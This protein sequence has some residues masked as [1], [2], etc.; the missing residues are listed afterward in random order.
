M[1]LLSRRNS[2]F[3]V[4]YDVDTTHWT[5]IFQLLFECA[6]NTGTCISYTNTKMEPEAPSSSPHA[7]VESNQDYY[8]A[9]FH[10]SKR[11]YS[12]SRGSTYVEPVNSN[13]YMET[14]QGQ[15]HH[16]G[17]P[18]ENLMA[19]SL[20]E[21]SESSKRCRY[22]LESRL[23]P[24]TMEFSPEKKASQNNLSSRAC[25]S[26][27]PPTLDRKPSPKK[28]IC[29]ICEQP[30]D[31]AG[32][33]DTESHHEQVRGNSLNTM[34]KYYPFLRNRTSEYSSSTMMSVSTTDEDPQV[35]AS[36]LLNRDISC[37]FCERDDFCP[38]CPV[39]ACIQ[40]HFAFCFFCRTRNANGEWLCV[41]CCCESHANRSNA[42]EMQLD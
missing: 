38:H 29:R 24:E 18:S 35:H 32:S 19:D 20:V 9:Q 14:H 16:F 15:P 23:H 5:F 27:P 33:K 31:G 17:I 6:M 13:A 3:G 25:W 1:T 36:S 4:V 8:R 21:S 22:T 28:A 7:G 12:R 26:Q 40:C 39:Q 34:L 41:S 11:P 10:S 42:A 37:H 30:Y 2:R